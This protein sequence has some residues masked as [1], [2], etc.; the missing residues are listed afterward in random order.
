[1]DKRGSNKPSTRYYEE[2]A[3]HNSKKSSP[4]SVSATNSYNRKY[5]DLG[6]HKPAHK[7]TGVG[8]V[9][10]KIKP[11]IIS[12]NRFMSKKSNATSNYVIVPGV[13]PQYTKKA[14]I[15]LHDNVYGTKK[16]KIDLEHSPSS[17]TGGRSQIGSYNS[18]DDRVSQATST[19]SAVSNYTSIYGTRAYRN[20]RYA[21]SPIGQAQETPRP[22]ENNERRSESPEIAQESDTKY[23]V[24]E[25][26]LHSTQSFGV[27]YVR[28]SIIKN[29]P[30][31]GAISTDKAVQIRKK[32]K[33]NLSGTQSPEPY[34]VIKRNRLHKQSSLT[35]E[36]PGKMSQKSYMINYASVERNRE[37]LEV[38]NYYQVQKD[39]PK[40]NSSSRRVNNYTIAKAP[41]DSGSTKSQTELM[42]KSLP[43]HKI[44]V[45]QESGHF[46]THL[47]ELQKEAYFLISDS[48]KAL[49][50]TGSSIFSILAF[51][52]EIISICNHTVEIGEDTEHIKKILRTAEEFIESKKFS[53]ELLESNIR[54]N[55]EF[56]SQINQFDKVKLDKQRIIKSENN[57]SNFLK[58]FNETIFAESKVKTKFDLDL[59][60]ERYASKTEYKPAK[61][62]PENSNNM[63]K[64]GELLKDADEDFRSPTEGLVSFVKDHTKLEA[65]VEK[66]FDEKNDFMTKWERYCNLVSSALAD[67]RQDEMLTKTFEKCTQHNTDNIALLHE[68]KI[69]LHTLSTTDPVKLSNNVNDTLEI[70][71]KMSYL[72]DK[73]NAYLKSQILNC[74]FGYEYDIIPRFQISILKTVHMLFESKN[75]FEKE[76]ES[77]KDQISAKTKEF[78]TLKEISQHKD[79]IDRMQQVCHQ[80]LNMTLSKSS[81]IKLDNKAMQWIRNLYGDKLYYQFKEADN[82]KKKRSPRSKS[83][84]KSKYAKAEARQIMKEMSDIINQVIESESSK[85]HNETGANSYEGSS[86]KMQ[87][88]NITKLEYLKNRLEEANNNNFNSTTKSLFDDS[89]SSP[90]PF[91]RSMTKSVDNF[92]DFDLKQ[93]KF[94]LDEASKAQ[95]DN[96]QEYN[97]TVNLEN[98][99]LLNLTMIDKPTVET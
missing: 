35:I 70:I 43:R 11:M 39:D 85:I 34:T 76:I 24:A 6:S 23:K 97:K 93:F 54:A 48:Q 3:S 30:R 86:S 82:L 33:L 78:E 61:Q 53:T 52:K 5:K 17:S 37:E 72:T 42:N 47:D 73:N 21:A 27:N 2:Q 56:L 25:I 68:A 79:A 44:E 26:N 90:G 45:P 13:N 89:M 9:K 41:K 18:V 67:K 99:K 29:Q 8:G 66:D 49:K 88:E 84:R 69:L 55:D 20:F 10:T 15:M 80:L 98:L 94:S 64:I 16:S 91:N 62:K 83:K 87:N 46:W 65:I 59:D 7:P 57:T 58:S 40:Q 4:K 32:P 63:G 75:D 77:L 95:L 12:D 22:D 19:Y 38:R 71:E 51:Y 31:V 14:N 50:D 36:T 28:S 60:A 96:T 92:G 1:M 74:D 81:Q